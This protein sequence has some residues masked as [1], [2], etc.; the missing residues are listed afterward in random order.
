MQKHAFLIAAPRSNSGKTLI[1]LGLIGALVKRGYRVQ[2]YK[3]GPDYIDPMH[4][5]HVAG[6]PSYN[7]DTWMASAEHMQEVYKRH[8]K[9]ADVAVIEGVMGLFDGAQKDTGSPAE[10]ARLLRLPVVLV[11][12]ASSMAYSAAPLLFGFKNFDQHI[13]LA[14]VIFN[15]VGSP[16]HA[17][18]LNE[19]A[20]DA[21]VEVLGC[22]P[23]DSRL[24]IGS[25]HLGLHLP[26]ESDDATVVETASFLIGEHVDLDK[27]LRQ[28]EFDF[29]PEEEKT[30]V[31]AKKITIAIAF[32]EAFCF[33]Y[34]ENMDVLQS[35]GKVKFFSPLKDKTLPR[36]DWVWL[37]GGYPELFAA[38]L[39]R[40]KTMSESIRAYVEAGKPL[41]AE[42][43]GMMYLGK[44]MID[45]AGI[46]WAMTGLFD[47]STTF[48]RMRLHM[49]Y[50]SIEINDFC[51]RG[52]EF[53]YSGLLNAPDNCCP[54]NVKTAREEQADMQVFRYKNCWASYMHLYLGERAKMLSFMN[55]L[56]VGK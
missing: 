22:V 8:M 48:E 39:S 15:K 46:R 1:T 17:R 5:R 49:G 55:F 42:C 47:F 28:G 24:A 56:D 41:V 13:R 20:C 45:K 4:H 3:C 19:A 25:R 26:C 43:G 32:D 33:T 35:L 16:D 18:F 9:I 44:E 52:H 30:V 54:V 36:A 38:E 10:I 11:V 50:R 2:P 31:P 29:L 34:Q 37:P 27:L 21:G 53:H 7:L 40:N 12:D 14:G 23:R 6:S 51:L